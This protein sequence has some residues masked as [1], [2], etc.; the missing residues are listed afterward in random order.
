M[1]LVLNWL[2][3]N[4]LLVIQ[5]VSDLAAILLLIFRKTKVVQKL[6]NTP[7]HVIMTE[8]PTYITTAEGTGLD[9]HDKKQYVLS[10]ALSRLV[11]LTGK[12]LDECFTDYVTIIDRAVE[13]ILKTPQR[14]E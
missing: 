4:Y 8:L 10:L 6:E 1:K 2:S 13:D 9:G 7:L 12:S 5:L 11:S 3:E 14:K